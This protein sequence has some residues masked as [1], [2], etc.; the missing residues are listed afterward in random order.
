M[1]M[2]PSIVKRVGTGIYRL[3]T[4]HALVSELAAGIVVTT[5]SVTG[6][7]V[8]ATQ[9]ISSSV[10]GVGSAACKKGVHWLVAKDILTA[11]FLTIPAAAFLAALMYG[12]IFRWVE[13]A[14]PGW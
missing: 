6:G 7:P 1:S 10:M 4:F 3:R 9:V 5:G 8:S 12:L 14:I 13:A 2:A 11:W